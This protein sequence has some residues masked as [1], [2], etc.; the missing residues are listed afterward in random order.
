MLKPTVPASVMVE[1]IRSALGR[2][3]PEVKFCRPHDLDISIVGGG[4]SLADTWRDLNGYIAAINGSMAYLLDKGITPNACG[5]LD[6]NHHIVDMVPA[7]K[8]VTY[9]V[10]SVCDPDLFDKLRDCHVV[11]WHPTAIP[12]SEDILG[13]RLQVGGGCT[14][15]LRWINLAYVCGFRSFHLHG[16]DSSFR[17]G[18][19]HAYPDYRDDDEHLTVNGYLTRLNFL[20]QITDFAGMLARLSM[21]DVDPINIEVHGDGLLQNGW[22]YYQKVKGTMSPQEAF[23]RC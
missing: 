17:D 4:P 11:L 20:E 13:G 16:M 12:F 5:L 22:R 10:A 1:N 8:D 7:H 15:G 9:F 21:P 14:M 19:T 3:L 6:P 18:K 2:G 23:Q